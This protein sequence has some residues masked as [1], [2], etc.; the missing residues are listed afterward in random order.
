MLV[1]SKMV[2]NLVNFLPQAISIVLS[3]GLAFALNVWLQY[4]LLKRKNRDKFINEML[5]LLEEDRNFYAAYWEQSAAD[6]KE[7]VSTN[8][9]MQLTRFYHMLEFANDKYKI[10]NLEEM[11]KEYLR[12]YDLAVK[13]DF[14]LSDRKADRRNSKLIHISA[15]ELAVY[16][17]Q[18][19]I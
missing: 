10:K 11:Q 5:K 18:N 15:N 8:Q 2:D 3:V 6:I 17:W 1:F 7:N 9:T 4:N 19:K 16:L 12:F 14:G 13:A